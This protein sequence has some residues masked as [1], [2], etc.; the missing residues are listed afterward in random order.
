MWKQAQEGLRRQAKEVRRGGA[1]IA[2]RKESPGAENAVEQ[3]EAVPVLRGPGQRLL[4][5]HVRLEAHELQRKLV[6]AV[7]ADVGHG[8]CA[9][10]GTTVPEMSARRAGILVYP[11]TGA[12]ATVSG[13]PGALFLSSHVRDGGQFAVSLVGPPGFDA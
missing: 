4:G 12:S 10:T 2:I 5:D 9:G 7:A 3:V 1:G 6:L 11:A 13:A 8:G